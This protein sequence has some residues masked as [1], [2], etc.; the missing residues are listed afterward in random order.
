[1][2]SSIDFTQ[3]WDELEARIQSCTHINASMVFEDN[4]LRNS[5]IIFLPVLKADSEATVEA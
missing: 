5:D 4:R 2:Y 3:N 1:M